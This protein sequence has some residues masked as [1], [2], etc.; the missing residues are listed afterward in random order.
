MKTVFALD[1]FKGSISSIDA[2]RRCAEEFLAVFPDGEAVCVP[3]ADG[4][5]GTVE[6]IHHVLGGEMI[7]KTVTG[8][9]FRPVSASYLYIAETKT[10]VI[11]MAAASGLPL[12]EIPTA[13]GST[14]RGTGELMLDAA[15]RGAEQIILGLG[16]SATNDGGTGAL[17]AMGV[18]FRKADRSLL[19]PTGFALKELASIDVSGLCE[20]VKNC[21]ITIACDV[22]NPLCGAQ[23]ASAIYG[24]QKGATPEEVAILDANLHH[25]A[26]V[27]ATVTEKDLLGLVGGGAAGGMAAGISGFLNCRLQSGIELVLDTVN[28]S[29]IIAGADLV[30]TG[31]GRIDHQSACGKVISGIGGRCK[32]AGIPAIAIVGDMGDGYAAA[33]DFGITAVFSTNH[34][35]APFKEVRHRAAED[36]SDTAR[37]VFRF[38][39]AMK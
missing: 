22:S 26:E 27:A 29:S 39:G 15:L 12:M 3:I 16:G 5:E 14:T 7:T 32:A 4:G 21:Q 1:S 9:D 37:N 13:G 2:C 18:R 17:E 24:P 38:L 25:F 10:A 28:F 11:E 36:L 34:L 30:V 33:Y 23:G 31:E 19:T 35:A 20:A 6:A 8:P